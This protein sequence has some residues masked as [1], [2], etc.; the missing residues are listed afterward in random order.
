MTQRDERLT[1][2]N[3]I[4]VPPPKNFCISIVEDHLD[5]FELVK[6]LLE[7]QSFSV[8]TWDTV[9]AVTQQAIQTDCLWVV[10]KRLGDQP[11]GAKLFAELCQLPEKRVILFT[12]FG[13]ANENF[14]AVNFDQHR[15]TVSLAVSKPISIPASSGKVVDFFDYFFKADTLPVQMKLQPDSSELETYHSLSFSEQDDVADRVE[16]RFSEELDDAWASGAVWACILGQDKIDFLSRSSP[17]GIPTE[18]ELVE[19][20]QREQ[21]PAF[22]FD[23]SI[24]TNSTPLNASRGAGYIGSYPTVAI[25]VPADITN[26]GGDLEIPDIFEMHFDTGADLSFFAKEFVDAQPYATIGRSVKVWL[27][28]QKHRARLLD[29]VMLL[30][31]EFHGGADENQA[32]RVSRKIKFKGLSV[33]N[34]QTSDLRMDCGDHCENKSIAGQCDFR[35]FGL[36]GRDVLRENEIEVILGNGDAKVKIL[37]D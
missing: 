4:Q 11:S 6:S 28:S 7:E 13:E 5:Q 17:D 37:R 32:S 12:A 35:R 27:Q 31:A 3:L 33:S 23:K 22:V 20:E 14:G 18:A 26:S 34:W 2:T 21:K 25:S 29:L 15:K 36:L 30:R 19:L 24:A 10:D 16:E 1:R 9:E 8:R